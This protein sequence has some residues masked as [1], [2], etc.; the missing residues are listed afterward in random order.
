V[1]RA[2]GSVSSAGA[3]ATDG[4]A[5]GRRLGSAAP[6]GAHAPWPPFSAAARCGPRRREPPLVREER[7]PRLGAAAFP[8]CRSL[9]GGRRRWPRRRRRRG[10]QRGA[11]A[12]HGLWGH[13]AEA[14]AHDARAGVGGADPVFQVAHRAHAGQVDLRGRGPQGRREGRSRD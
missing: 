11:E 9:R 6:R 13:L 8:L 2:L 5:R 1:A 3:R 10:R 12:E 4:V 14:R 7:H